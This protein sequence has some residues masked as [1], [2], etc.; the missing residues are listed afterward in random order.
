MMQRLRKQRLSNLCNLTIRQQF[1]FF[2][3]AAAVSGLT[4][5][6][7]QYNWSIFARRIEVCFSLPI[8]LISCLGCSNVGASL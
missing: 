8:W 4:A 2:A 1:Y 7:G 6:S 5:G 3:I